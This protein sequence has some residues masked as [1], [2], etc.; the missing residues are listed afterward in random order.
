MPVRGAHE[1]LQLCLKHPVLGAEV[2]LVW[3]DRILT[4]SQGDQKTLDLH[5]RLT[6]ISSSD[7]ARRREAYERVLTALHAHP[8]TAME[9]RTEVGEHITALRPTQGAASLFGTKTKLPYRSDDVGL[10]IVG[11]LNYPQDM[12][13]HMRLFHVTTDRLRARVVNDADM[14]QLAQTPLDQLFG[15]AAKISE[16]EQALQ[17]ARTRRSDLSNSMLERE[18]REE[19][20]SQELEVKIEEQQKVR[21]FGV[22]SIGVVAIGV[23]VAVMFS[24]ALGAIV[25]AV[26]LALA[27]VGRYQNKHADTDGSEIMN[28]EL[29]VQMGR[30]GELFD[31][32]DLSRHRRA[33]EQSLAD[34]HATWRSIAGN[35]SPTVLLSDRPR[36][37]E[38]SSYLRLIDNEPVEIQ[39][40]TTLLVGFASLLAELNRRF[41]AERVPLLIDDV[42]QSVPTQYHGVMRELIIRASHRR[43]VILESEDA[44]VTK[45][46]AVEAVGGDAMLISDYDIDVEPIIEQAIASEPTSTV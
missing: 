31:T 24:Q 12:K 18:S 9:I 33:A 40:D 43:Q 21:T 20:L 16:D 29:E 44:V 17:D 2:H 39:G 42:F 15:L 1:N 32:H 19:V 10:G 13:S 5:D 7:T 8:G 22:A 28:L 45:W 25:C 27:A 26:A 30:V 3:I 4:Q 11:Q 36:I 6:V 14:I 23:A 35:A 41:P 37:E 38:L 46:A 34:S